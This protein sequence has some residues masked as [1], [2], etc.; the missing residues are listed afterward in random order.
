ME[1][2]DLR[3]L[4]VEDESDSAL[5]IS[6]ALQY[7]GVRTWSAASAEEGLLLLDS[8]QP[9]L[10]LVDLALPGMDG[11]EFLKQIQANPA[12]ENIPAVVVS[13]YLTPT[14]AKKAIEAGFRACFPKPIDTTLLV[15]QLIDVVN[16]R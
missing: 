9:N 10:L 14:V 6:S 2:S 15:R 3:V 16:E 5:V 13:A 8:V 12:T 4:V 1:L 11:W 7:G